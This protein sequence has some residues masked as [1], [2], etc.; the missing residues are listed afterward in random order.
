GW[1]VAATEGSLR[2]HSVFMTTPQGVT[3][4]QVAWR[5]RALRLVRLAAST[6]STS[7]AT[8][9]AS[10]AIS[11]RGCPPGSAGAGAGTGAGG[12]L[13]AGERSPAHTPLWA[14]CAV[15]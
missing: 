5:G 12:P 8:S 13:G 10:D 6:A 9:T 3:R 15:A 11:Q 4:A 1:S 7:A 2:S 14:A